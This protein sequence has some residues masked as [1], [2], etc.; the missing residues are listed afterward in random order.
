MWKHSIGAC[1]PE[2]AP[3]VPED[4]IAAQI[5]TILQGLCAPSATP[6]SRGNK[7]S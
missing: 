5:D 6:T 4:Y 3:I 7:P 2:N 1:V